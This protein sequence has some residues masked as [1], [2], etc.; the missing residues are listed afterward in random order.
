MGSSE[1]QTYCLR[2]N[3]HKT[4]LVEILDILIKMEYYVDCTIVVDEH[5][6]FK[7]HR[8]ILAA[9]SPYFQTILMDVPMDHC[10]ILFP[11]VKEFEMRALLEYMYTGEVNVTQSQIPRI[12][13]IAEQLEV[14]GLFDMT[15][16]RQRFKQEDPE[17]LRSPL[18]Y[19]S[20][21]QP[22]HSSQGESPPA[23][24]LWPN[25]NSFGSPLYHRLPTVL[26]ASY[27]TPG[28][29]NP[30][31]RKKL[32]SI[33]SMLMSRDTPI[34]RNVLAQTS[35]ADSSQ[36]AALVCQPVTHSERLH[37]NGSSHDSFKHQRTDV[38]EEA[39]SPYADKSFDD[40]NS[41]RSL[42]LSTS[43][44]NFPSDL[45]CGIA[46]YV[47]QQKPEWK[48]YKQY[49]RTDIMSAIECVRNGMS[50]LQASRKF[51][52][53]SR[54]LYDKVKKLGITTGRPMNRSIK[55]ES[56]GSGWGGGGGGRGGDDDL[57]QA[58]SLLD[59]GFLQQALE[60]RELAAGRDALHAMALAACAH[61]A[62]AP[63]RSP[64]VLKLAGRGAHSPAHSHSPSP[65]ASAPAPTPSRNGLHDS[66]E[67]HV[68][69]LSCR[70]SDSEPAGVIVTPMNQISAIIKKEDA[71][72][73]YQEDSRRSLSVDC[74]D[75]E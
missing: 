51:G 58:A 53:P 65:P 17:S 62:L 40:E 69:D 57:H 4:N 16:L 49:T 12:M 44:Q 35:A 38:S 33:S 60:G 25:S 2:W 7:A 19:N 59:A 43:P 5:V 41:H 67:D 9:N 72:R 50:A 28:D 30:L 20:S 61:A 26:S 29:M 1:G 74:S 18:S 48:R 56:N 55:R 32:S 64:G 47:P 34:L 73:D 14:K 31:K 23:A 21:Q 45:R 66:D 36:S 24:P 42:N 52:V 46:P 13:K 70:R 3:N 6:Q 22:A 11:G 54:T 27:D 75:R 37:S 39:H 63:P 8:V 15:E 68:E 71:L 10:S